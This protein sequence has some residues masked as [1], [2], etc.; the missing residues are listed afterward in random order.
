MNT[1]SVPE[2]KYRSMFRPT[3]LWRTNKTAPMMPASDD[4]TEE[5]P[6]LVDTPTSPSMMKMPTM[7]LP[8]PSLPSFHKKPDNSMALKETGKNEV[9]ELSTVNDSGVYLAPAPIQGK[10][11]HWLG[12]DEDAFRFSLPSNDCL[13]TMSGRPH[14]FYTPSSVMI[15]SAV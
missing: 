4:K 3:K 10:H 11:D 7:K 8:S 6:G 9:Y 14:S 12:V 1:A 15:A 2:S 5:K 13:T